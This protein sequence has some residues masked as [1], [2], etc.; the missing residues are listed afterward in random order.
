M[1]TYVYECVRTHGTKYLYKFP[2]K[3]NIVSTECQYR[4]PVTS[5][6]TKNGSFWFCDKK[7]SC[8]FIC[9]FG[10]NN[11]ETDLHKKAISTWQAT[12]LKQS[13]CAG[14]GKL[15]KL[16]VIMRSP[17]SQLW[18]TILCTPGQARSVLFEEWSDVPLLKKPMFRHSF[19]CAVCKM[20]KE[21]HNEG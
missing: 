1:R 9:Y 10:Q 19:A 20:K 17:E 7:P 11:K 8:N 6:T 5:S 4:A 3:K 16:C 12:N 13:K 21:C 15:A 18:T 2:H 14:Y